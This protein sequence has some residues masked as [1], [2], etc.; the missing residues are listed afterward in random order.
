MKIF[1]AATI[2]LSS[3]VAQED[4]IL[5]SLIQ[6][7]IAAA[8]GIPS[9]AALTPPGNRPNTLTQPQA[10]LRPPAVAAN[11]VHV[12]QCF[13][14]SAN[15]YGDCVTNGVPVDCGPQEGNCFLMEERRYNRRSRANE[16]VRVQ[17]GCMNAKACADR[18]NRNFLNGPNSP[19]RFNQCKADGGRHSV[20]HQCCDDKNNC[21]YEDPVTSMWEPADNAE[22]DF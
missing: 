11:R 19:A 9:D 8:N 22:W 5:E 15:S 4:A 17:T 20:C 6:Q 12:T 14:C 1:T 13:R 7:A 21:V 3:A 10:K 18:K 16:V 2:L